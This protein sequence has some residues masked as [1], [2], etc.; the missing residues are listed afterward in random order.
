M[1]QGNYGNAAMNPQTILKTAALALATFALLA[2]AACSRPADTPPPPAA[3][4]EPIVFADL[5]W[6]SAQT[7]NRIAQYL[8]EKGYGYPTELVFGATLP[9]FQGLRRGDIDVDMEMW[10]PNQIDVW[11]EARDAGEVV[12]LGGSLGKDWQSAFVIPAY[13]QERYPDLDSVEDLKDERFKSLFAT[14]DSHGKARLV[15]CL[16][17]WACESVN[18]EQVAGYGLSEH[19]DIVAPG[20]AA[21]ANA[22]LYS[23]YE[24]GEA[25][26]GY[27]AGTN[28]PALILDLVRL[29]EPPYSDECWATTKACSYRDAD[30]LVAVNAA[31]PARAPDAV[32]ALR[33]YD[34][35]AQRFGEIFRW[36]HANENAALEDAA[37]WWLKGNADIWGAWVSPEAKANIQ[38]ALDANEMADGWPDS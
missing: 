9:L 23:A 30:V 34:L 19:V 2:L 32:E 13:L 28:D 20:D 4:K 11:E 21:T 15:S 29:A 12:A 37:L 26:L 36:M 14:P 31:L 7:Q 24:K 1:K 22:S 38:A 8:I 5:N 25:W 17:G 6:T 35:G 18:A 3:V 10:L 33:A 16:I 27:Q